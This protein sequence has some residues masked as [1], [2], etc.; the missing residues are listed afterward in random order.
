M[1]FPPVGC[2]KIHLSDRRTRTHANRCEILTTGK[3]QLPPAARSAH[4]SGEPPVGS[5]DAGKVAF[6][7]LC[8]ALLPAT[9][10]KGALQVKSLLRPLSWLHCKETCRWRQLVSTSSMQF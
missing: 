10:K 1:R 3:P 7:G 2:C 8:H 5:V 9:R 4:R 6:A